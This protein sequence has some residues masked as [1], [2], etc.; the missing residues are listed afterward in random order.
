LPGAEERQ[1]HPSACLYQF[2]ASGA[3]FLST[4]L[5]PFS[6]KFSKNLPEN[7]KHCNN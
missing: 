1:T 6:F 3:G 2:S 7:G 5:V 4:P